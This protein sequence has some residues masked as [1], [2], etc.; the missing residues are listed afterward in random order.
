MEEEKKQ[1]MTDAQLQMERL[2]KLKSERE[3]RDRLKR[4]QP[5]EVESVSAT[6]GI[7]P[8]RPEK[9][10]SGARLPRRR[11]GTLRLEKRVFEKLHRIVSGI[12]APGGP[13]ITKAR[14]V[15]LVIKE[16]LALDIDYNIVK[17]KDEMK[18]LFERIKTGN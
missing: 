14:F 3:K 2:L 9:A 5:E 16:F 10:M 15:N 7:K 17:S 8:D 4:E 11:P 18:R 12:N 13:K 6:A 1:G